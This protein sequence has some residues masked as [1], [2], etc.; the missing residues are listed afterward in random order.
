MNTLYFGDNLWHLQENISDESVDLVYLDPPFNSN[1]QYNV[2]FKTPEGEA[3]EA[4]A[5]AFKDAWTWTG[6]AELAFDEIIRSGGAVVPVLDALRRYL[7]ESDLMAYL[8]MMTSRLIEL[9]RSLKPTGTIYLHCDPTASHYLKLVMDGIFGPARYRNEISWRRS[10]PK[11]HATRNF[12]NA[13]DILLR[14]TKGDEWTFHPVHVEHDPEYVRK[15]YR[16]RDPDGRVYRLGDLTNPNKNRPNLTYTFLGVKRVWR[17]TQERMEEANE[18]GIIV[19]SRPGAVPALKRYLDEMPGTPVTN[20]WDDIEHLHGGDP[21]FLGYPT[22]KPLSLL[23]RVIKASTNAGDIVLDPFCGCGTAIEAAQALERQW[24]GIDITHYAISLIDRRLAASFPGLQPH[25]DGRPEDMRAARLLAERDAF[26]FQWWANWLVGVQNYRER[27]RGPDRGIDGLIFFPNGPHG[28]GRVVVSVKSGKLKADD[29][30]SLSH[31]V[32]R[33]NAQ[34]GLLVTLEEPSDRM[35]ADAAAAGI[36]RAPNEPYPRLQ[37]VTVESLLKGIR[38]KMPPAIVLPELDR[39]A[40][41]RKLEEAISEQMAFHFVFSTSAAAKTSDVVDH[42][43]PALV[44][45]SLRRP[46]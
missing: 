35:I 26:Q 45:G 32:Q 27:R 6:D 20:D 30:R 16:H 21:E 17:W 36:V 3:S 14:Y 13:R 33:E 29:V 34:I 2:F 5:E 42:L 15:F 25:I 38:P 24:I 44:L 41:R 39:R 37:I 10:Q 7:K 28:V 31:V 12:S 40:S 8:V 9:H 4:Q 19:Q 1:A 22:Q 23:E 11:G 43:D 46:H 18:A